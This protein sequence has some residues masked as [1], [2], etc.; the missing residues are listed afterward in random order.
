M[1]YGPDYADAY[2][3]QGLYTARI[4]KGG[5][6]ADLPVIQATK[7]TLVVNL[8]TAKKLGLT[9]SRDF[10]ARVDEVIQ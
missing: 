1:S 4:L 5:K 6:P 7:F 3:Q 8:K 9:V 2:R 10:L